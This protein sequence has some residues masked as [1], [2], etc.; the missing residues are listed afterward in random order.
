M[1]SAEDPDQ[2]SSLNWRWFAT[3]AAA[4]AL[5][6]IV[7]VIAS[8]LVTGRLSG[9]PSLAGTPAPTESGDGADLNV[10]QEVKGIWEALVMIP[11]G[12]T[13][14][15]ASRNFSPITIHETFGVSGQ[16]CVVNRGNQP[17]EGLYMRGDLQYAE[18]SGLYQDMTGIRFEYYAEEQLKPGEGRCYLYRMDF[19]PVVEASYRIRTQVTVQNG[20]GYL[21]GGKNCPGEERCPTGPRID[22]NF[23]LPSEP[24]TRTEITATPFFPTATITITP[25]LTV[26][27]T[28]TQVPTYTRTITQTRTQVRSATSTV[29]N[30][31]SPTYTATPSPST[32]STTTS[33][34]TPSQTSTETFTSTA[35]S[36]DTPTA[37]ATSTNTATLTP[38]SE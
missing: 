33:T 12:G 4:V 20:E 18:P 5:V 19:L 37:T 34:A 36:G 9:L 15:S 27:P 24:S 26:G 23:V 38:A 31:F 13:D 8:A 25:T 35:T 22:T 16:V 2:K 32:T 21:P 6:G 17:T 28:Y 10:T 7:A 29:T 11:Y 1:S 3:G 14:A 30:T